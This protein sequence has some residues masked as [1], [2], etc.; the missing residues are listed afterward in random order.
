MKVP[1]QFLRILAAGALALAMPAF[2]AFKPDTATVNAVPRV[3][4]P[5]A[6]VQ[7]ALAVPAKDHPFQFAVPV[8]RHIALAD[9]RWDT[10]DAQTLSWRVRI[11]SPGAH[12][13]SVHLAPLVLP[14]SARLWVY[15]AAGALVHGPYSA[16]DAGADGLWTP[17]VPDDELVLEL[18]VAAADA[19]AVK[20]ATATVYHGF[21]GWKNAAVSGKSGSCNVDVVC[22]AGAPWRD[23]IRAVERIT[24]G[25]TILCSGELVNNTRQDLTPFFL[26]ADHCGIGKSG[27]PASS[28]VFYFNY[29]TSTCGGSP[30]GN[31]GQTLS[32]SGLVAHDSSSDF[33]LLQISQPI[34]D[35]FNVFFAGWNVRGVGSQCGAAIHHP[36][37]DEKRISLYGTPLTKTT[38]DVDGAQVDA[39]R[40]AWAKGTTEPGSS[41]GGLWNSDHQMIGVL[42][43][44]TAS[45]SNPSGNDYFGR[46]DAAWT[47]Q[48]TPGGQLKA[49]LD[50]DNT[51][52][53]AIPGRDPKRPPLPL[54]DVTSSSCTE[55][56]S[57]G[58]APVGLL[59]FLLAAALLR[60]RSRINGP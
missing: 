8:E 54:N 49:H 46:L 28:V 34:P 60:V 9:G 41:G 3:A 2:A 15:D 59:P 11:G 18:R 16:A 31:L 30:D 55:A 25:G 51:G 23:E 19:P 24:I 4:L 35:A 43:G 1:V 21:R 56:G 17:V 33:S 14:P 57:G 37:G 26:T 7:K 38:V 6:S 36:N 12:S 50:P 45:C 47:A 27:E 48:S 13:L 52:S 39:W 29:E 44:G 5:A 40:V 20:L 53:T 22:P 10:L 32:G 58:G 42:S